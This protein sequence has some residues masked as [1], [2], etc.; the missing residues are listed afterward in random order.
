MIFRSE[1]KREESGKGE[2]GAPVG[3]SQMQ[4][5][6]SSGAPDCW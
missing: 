1:K 5:V 4:A 3:A 6:S 2:M